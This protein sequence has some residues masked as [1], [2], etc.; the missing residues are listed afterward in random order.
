MTP[1]LY[2]KYAVKLQRTQ[3]FESNRVQGTQFYNLDETRVVLNKIVSL[4]KFHDLKYEY[5]FIL[6]GHDA[7]KHG[8]YK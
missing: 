6:A 5:V 7:L 3:N 8:R 4:W 2:I 1:S